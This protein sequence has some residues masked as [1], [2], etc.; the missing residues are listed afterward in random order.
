MRQSEAAPA[1][2]NLALHVRRRRP[3]GYHELETLFAFVADGDV[4]AVDESEALSLTIEGPMADGLSATDNLVPSA[5]RRLATSA[6]IAPRA[7]LTLTKNLPV[8][9]G[10]GGG[11]A[12]AAAALRLLNRF[13]GLDYPL[14]RLAELAEPL[15]ADV[16]A[17]VYSRTM[18]G[19]GKGE[20][21]EPADVAGL[22]DMPVLLVNPMV[23]LATGPVF[24][25]WDGVDRGPLDTHPAIDDLVRARNDL[26][27]GAISLCPAIADVLSA[28]AACRG[29]LLS[30]MSGS[31]ATCFAL[32]ES[33]A[34]LRFAHDDL[35]AREPEWWFLP[36][37]VNAA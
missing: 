25:A 5:A 33:V 20:T 11:S 30:R 31:G 2:L 1:K 34:A 21:L 12:D 22:H 8:A 26:Q 9:S 35:A 36:T 14:D 4:V 18:W 3:D 23:P 32:F 6:G 17:C 15:G 16:P 13:W 19:G 29:A 10:I 7:R 37:R 27:P 24:A 28:L